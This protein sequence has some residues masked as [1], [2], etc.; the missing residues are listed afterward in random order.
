MQGVEVVAEATNGKQAV[1]LV[2]A[3]NPDV[4]LMDIAM[5]ELNGI[6]AA[7]SRTRTGTA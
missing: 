4:V 3:L 1:D 5:K 7:G 2:G 6:E